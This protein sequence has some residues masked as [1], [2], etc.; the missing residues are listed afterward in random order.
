MCLLFSLCSA[1]VVYKLQIPGQQEV[2]EDDVEVDDSSTYQDS[3]DSPADS[4]VKSRSSSPVTVK[5][6][7]E[8]ES[9]PSS[10]VTVKEEPRSPAAGSVSPVR[11]Q[12]QRVAVV[13][14]VTIREQTPRKKVTERATKGGVTDLCNPGRLVVRP[15]GQI[16]KPAVYKQELPI[17]SHA[18]TDIAEIDQS[19][20]SSSN[21]NS[22]TET[23]HSYTGSVK[24]GYES[25][26]PEELLKES[27]EETSNVSDKDEENISKNPNPFKY[28]NI[29]RSKAMKD[30]STLLKE[31]LKPVKDD[32]SP[33]ETELLEL[34]TGNEF[35]KLQNILSKELATGIDD[36][37]LNY[38][39]VE[40]KRRK[41][42]EE[43]KETVSHDERPAS[44]KEKKDDEDDEDDKQPQKTAGPTSLVGDHTGTG[45]LPSGGSAL[46]QSSVGEPKGEEANLEIVGKAE[47][48]SPVKKTVE[49]QLVSSQDVPCNEDIANLTQSSSF[50]NLE[51]LGEHLPEIEETEKGEEKT[52]EKTDSVSHD[53]K[54]VRQLDFEDDDWLENEDVQD[55]CKVAEILLIS[56]EKRQNEEK[57]AAIE[58]KGVSDVETS[59]Q[60][61]GTTSVSSDTKL[62]VSSDV[63]FKEP[64]TS[65]TKRKI[66]EVCT[67]E[68]SEYTSDDSIPLSQ[69]AKESPARFALISPLVPG[70]IF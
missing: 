67:S 23:E 21:S 17:V 16:R 56:D 36:E 2:V 27:S 66:S 60:T 26:V 50:D 54:I 58:T 30:F 59:V 33:S 28:I 8:A 42:L 6:E 43:E 38:V 65:G 57:N 31:T 5:E 1:G 4:P 29:M 12:V 22:D 11:E 52:E 48:V 15:A 46:S 49:E 45:N 63:S 70:N 53:E 34:R 7:A 44:I 37:L 19:S 13:A 51:T 35:L 32:M 62:S 18:P 20:Q 24:S 61:D 39:I 68:S 14:K 9:C 10:P 69:L 55:E 40:L 47:S 25:N 64:M 41:R 3:P